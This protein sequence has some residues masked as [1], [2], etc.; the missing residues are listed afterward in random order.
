[1]DSYFKKNFQYSSGI[2]LDAQKQF[3]SQEAG[4]D[5]IEYFVDRVVFLRWTFE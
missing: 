1:M 4:W 3:V 2:C 5:L